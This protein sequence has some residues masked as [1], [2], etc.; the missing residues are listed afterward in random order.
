MDTDRNLLFGVLALQAD[1]ID[2]SQL[3]EACTAWAA[4]KDMPLA[5]ILIER[6]WITS[7]DQADVRRVLERKLKKQNQDP[8]ATLIAVLSA[9]LRLSLAA[10]DIPEITKT[11]DSLRKDGPDAFPLIPAVPLTRE[12]YTLTRLHAT[13]GIGRVWVARDEQ[14]GRDVALKELRA[15]TVG[16]SHRTRFLREAR[17]TGQLEHPSIV[18]VY[19]LSRRP[20]NQ[21]PFYTMRLVQGRTLS[22]AAAAFHQRRQT[23]KASALDLRELLNAFVAICQAVAYAH[24][25]GV[26][27]RD[28]KGDNVLLGDFGEALV[29]DWGL[30]K[31][32][33]HDNGDPSRRP[34]TVNQRDDALQ[35]TLEGQVLGTPAFMPPEQAAGRG[36]Q[37]DERADV[38]GLGAILYEVLTGQ[39][40]F[41]A[42]TVQEVLRKVQREEPPRPREL[43]TSVPPALEAVCLRAL[44]KMPADRYASARDLAQEVQRWLADEPVEAYPEP[45]TARVARW[46]RRHRPIMTAALA[47]LITAL[48]ALVVGNFLIGEQ[49]ARAE[50]NAREANK[51]QGR[52]E[53]HLHRAQDAV[54]RYH[55]QVSE[56]VLLKE[57][58]L[59]PLRKKL[60]ETALQ[61][62]QGFVEEEPGDLALEA[63]R[64]RAYY[65]L[66]LLTADIGSQPRAIDLLEQ[67]R[68]TFEN[69]SQRHPDVLSYRKNLGESYQS[70]GLC[71]MATGQTDLAEASF[72]KVLEIFR[73]LAEAPSSAGDQTD[74]REDVQG[75]GDDDPDMRRAAQRRL[76]MG[77]NNLGALYRNTRRLPEAERFFQAGL[78]VR[79]ELNATPPRVPAYQRDLAESYNNLGAFYLEGK[80]FAQ[81]EAALQKAVDIRE[82]LAHGDAAN[83]EYQKLWARTIFNLG[84]V[85]LRTE[86][87]SSAEEAFT[88]SRDILQR[89]ADEN[90]T[91]SAFQ[92]NLAISLQNLGG[93]Y[94]QAGRRADAEQSYGKAIALLEKLTT[95]H[96]TNMEFAGV[97]GRTYGNMGLLFLESDSPEAA[98][99]WLDRSVSKLADVLRQDER[100]IDARQGLRKAHWWRAE[101]LNALDRHQQALA[102]WSAA[103]DLDNGSSRDEL[104]LHRAR[105]LALLKE[106]ASALADA[107]AVAGARDAN[108]K[109]LC[110][111]A[112]VYSVSAAN[113]DEAKTA[114]RYAARAVALLRHA[115][116][117]GFKDLAAIQNEKDFAALRSRKDFQG[118]LTELEGKLNKA[119]NDS[120]PHGAW[121]GRKDIE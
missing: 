77:Y 118:L 60:L 83:Q 1:L 31:V 102:D 39:P 89:L 16:Q 14:V 90:P 9:D 99:G 84:I 55:T 96:R 17:I 62:Y 104:R 75:A 57:P 67:A 22:A 13:G 114:D 18:P 110:Q 108:A 37:V 88:R 73:P 5:S 23:G 27:H 65:R 8:R 113:S 33:M 119:P 47:L 54:Y 79:L 120:E 95:V 68:T 46:G 32:R 36:D 93:F 81:A 116:D 29:L 111:A 100:S 43:W 74:P 34:V 49:K 103:L 51:Q 48:L 40:P 59:Q 6:G 97:L 71:Y 50:A 92:Y 117:R 115:V 106:H 2:A 63:E 70:L 52:A 66:A 11:I 41:A 24:S 87:L 25:R 105:T 86:R 45:W 4:H 107:D 69:L 76:A 98:R 38:Y 26:I 15:E 10:L 72:Q 19:E 112:R 3:G 56:E 78:D 82:E 109:T 94:N 53:R 44:A 85:Y 28:L 30:A 121:A 7:G 12:R 21:Q 61:F 101:A 20:E 35:P 58:G 64:G 91:V 42:A 80:Q